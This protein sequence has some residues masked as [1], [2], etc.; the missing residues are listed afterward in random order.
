MKS[1][2]AERIKI[3]LEGEDYIIMLSDGIG[4]GAEETP[5]LLDLLSKPPKRDLKEYADSILASALKNM[6]HTDDM[7]VLVTRVIRTKD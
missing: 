3:E 7:T 6:A 4:Q 2:D 5:W 1:V